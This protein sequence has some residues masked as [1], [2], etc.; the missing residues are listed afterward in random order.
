MET[1]PG[2]A[3]GYLAVPDPAVSGPPPWPGVVVLHDITGLS[4]DLRSI[5]DRFAAAGYLALAPDLYSRGGAVR[6]VRAVFA[7]L[8]AGHGQAFADI[9]AARGWLR[10]RSDCTWRVGVAGFCMGGGFALATAARDFQAAAPYYG[11]LPRDP[12]ALDGACPIVASY[13][14]RDRALAG[15]AAR[16]RQA[17][18]DREIVHDVVEYPDAGHGFANRILPGPLNRVGHF[19]GFA[20]HHDS[21]EDAWRRVLAFFAD[22]LH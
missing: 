3:R 21:S 20:Y 6:C 8:R 1:L 9:E 4:G 17:L 19:A 10:G 5:T 14:G 16:L 11:P 15:S 7:A 22:H 13:G 12:G 18:T 2:G